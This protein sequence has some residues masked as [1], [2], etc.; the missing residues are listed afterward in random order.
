MVSL[1]WTEPLL[2]VALAWFVWISASG[3]HPLGE[4]FAFL[5]LPFLKQYVVAPVAMFAS[6]LRSQQPPLIFEDGLQRRD[7]V[8]VH[9]VVQA[10]VLAMEPG[11]ADGVA[12]NIGSGRAISIVEIAKTLAEAMGCEIEPEISYRYRGGDIRHCF[13]DISAAKNLLGYAPQVALQTGLEELVG[14]LASQRTEE[15]AARAAAE[16]QAQGLSA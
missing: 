9:D 15:R 5:L 14:W 6:R 8:S 12:L 13:A 11:F 1:G 2:L 4:A 16:L 7:F 3:H 10:N